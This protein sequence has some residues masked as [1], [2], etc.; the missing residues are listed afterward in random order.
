MQIEIDND[1]MVLL[2]FLAKLNKKTVEETIVS[3]LTPAV[4][5][6]FVK[7]QPQGSIEIATFKSLNL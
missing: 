7:S 1:T 4:T 5:R 3:I 2:T 6:A